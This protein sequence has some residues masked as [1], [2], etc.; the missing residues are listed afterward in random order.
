MEDE[1]L[2][3]TCHMCDNVGFDVAEDGFYYCSHCGSQAEDIIDTGVADED[4]VNKGGGMDGA[5]YSAKHTRHIAIKVEPLSQSQS[6]FQSQLLDNS[7]HVKKEELDEDMVDGVGPIG[8]SDFGSGMGGSIVPSFEAFSNEVR[9]RYVLGVQLMIEFQCQAL[10]EKF[11]VSPLVCGLAGTIWL[12]YVSGSRVFDDKWADDVYIDSENQKPGQCENFKP[13]AKYKD[14]LHNCHGQRAIMIWFR[15]LRKKI[16]LSC[17]LAISFLACHIAREAILPTDILKWS[18]EGK[19]PYFASF[20]EIEKKIGR[21]TR[22]CPI[23]S[24]HMFKP[25]QPVSLQKLE[26]MAASIAQSIGLHLPPVNFHAIA[27]LYLKQ[28]SLPV[29]KILPH[30]CRIYEWSMPPD[31]WLSANDLRLPTRVCVMSIL[32]VAIRIL[33]NIHGFGEWERSLS[34]HSG[35]STSSTQ[36]GNSDPKTEDGGSPSANFDDSDL[37]LDRSSL[38]GHKK[39]ELSAA[40]LLCN[41]E[42][43]CYE[44]NDPYEYSKDLPTYLQ[45]CKDVVFA[46][47]EPSYVHFKEANIIE[48]LWEFYQ[49]EIDG[50]SPK[51]RGI[52]CNGGLNQKRSRDDE[53]LKGNKK[54][55]ENGY[56]ELH[57]EDSGET[58]EDKAIRRLKLDMEDNRFCYIPPRSNLKRFDYLHYAR[59]KDEGSMIYVAHADYY[60]LL[61]ACARVAQV[62]TRI[63]HVGVLSLERRLD[64]LEKRIDHCI[65]LP[66]HG[67]DD[68]IGLSNLNL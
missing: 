20:V 18:L 49:E 16:P 61:R 30:A 26:S 40:E 11:E 15:Y 51:D 6:I 59:K 50:E 5:I 4:F 68:S 62:D 12:R 21:P 57:G 42:A 9:M 25:S 34:N 44:F 66:Q 27:S 60:I 19:L 53:L 35:M 22:A 28:L 13:R 67:M 10:V 31:L 41:L 7:N 8:P 33:Y 56:I 24:S 14:E 58:I 36:L 52:A 47:L 45:Y 29:E 17:S 54:I 3:L 1:R 48:K 32:I 65:H 64:W 39:I 46:G 37:E 23:S 43:K 2:T 63:M 55:R 38:N